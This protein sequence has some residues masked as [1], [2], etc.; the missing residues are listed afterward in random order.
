MEDSVSSSKLGQGR[1]SSVQRLPRQ[2]L[3]VCDGARF[4]AL[5]SRECYRRRSLMSRNYKDTLNLPRT[6][7]PMKADLTA[8]E[9]ELLKMWDATRLY[10]QI[11]KSRQDRQLFRSQGHAQSAAHR[12]PHESGPDR[13]RARAPQNVGRDPALSSDS[14]VPARS[15][16]VQISRTRSICR[17][18]ISP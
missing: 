8:R 14:K 3:R 17:A 13:A 6:D 4:I 15:T 9:P 12:F 11:Q 10:H 1:E 16:I 2:I 7:F 5:T 18:P